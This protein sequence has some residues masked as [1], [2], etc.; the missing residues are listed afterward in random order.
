MPEVVAVEVSNRSS[1]RSPSRY[2]RTSPLDARLLPTSSQA[3]SP[4]GSYHCPAAPT[5]ARM[6]NRATCQRG[7]P[8][9]GCTQRNL[10]RDG[11]DRTPAATGSA[12]RWQHC[13][14][15]A[16]ASDAPPCSLAAPALPWLAR[17]APRRQ[18]ECSLESTWSTGPAL[19]TLP[20]TLFL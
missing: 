9:A 20:R 16:Q 5:C 1:S 11:S 4:P 12:P 19:A 15:G 14:A 13:I 2:R 17:T 6:A 7:R 10:D 18:V 8:R 3:C